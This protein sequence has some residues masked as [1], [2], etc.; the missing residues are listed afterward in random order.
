M[1]WISLR[2]LTALGWRFEGSFPDEPKMVVVAYPHTSNWDFFIFLAALAHHGISASFLAA[3]GLFIGP[4]GWFLRRS[5]GIAV[6][7]SEARAVVADATSAF[8]DADQMVLVLAPEGTRRAVPV[9]RSGFWRI[10][11]AADVPVVMAAVDYEQRRI[12]I[13]PSERIA[14][15]PIAWMQRARAFYASSSGLHPERSSPIRIREEIPGT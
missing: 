6:D 9:W 5:G 11:D 10:A 14:G 2:V 3:Q 12:T 13:G 8:A 7:Q 4:F 15:D 1:R